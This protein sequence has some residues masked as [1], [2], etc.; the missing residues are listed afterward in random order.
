MVKPPV[1]QL[2]P[3]I[4]QYGK[5]LVL[6]TAVEADPAPVARWE[7]DDQ[8]LEE[9]PNYALKN[10]ALSVPD[11]HRL[12]L[13]IQ[14]FDKSFAGLYKC[15]IEN[16]HGKTTASFTVGAGD[17]PDFIDKPHIIQ[18][19]KGKALAIKIRAK[20]KVEPTV[21]WTKNE[22]PVKE[23][24]RIKFVTKKGESPEEYVLFLEIKGPVKE[25]EATYKC[26]VKN[27]DGSNSQSLDLA[28]D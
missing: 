26:V 7:K 4:T 18:R 2:E 22:K 12:T 17:L 21:E 10:E 27:P 6:E 3:K 20:S 25:D 8:P 23:D 24:G 1:I 13:Q 19:D 14:N 16:E 28:F 9:G 5:N 15:H 11:M